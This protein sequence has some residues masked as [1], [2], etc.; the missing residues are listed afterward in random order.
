V[1]MLKIDWHSNKTWGII[2]SIIAFLT[3]LL[4]I[5]LPPYLDKETQSKLWGFLWSNSLGLLALAL[6]VLLLFKALSQDRKLRALRKKIATE[7]PPTFSRFEEIKKVKYGH[8]AYRPLMYYDEGDNPQGVGLNLLKRIFA[9]VDLVD[10][11]RKSLWNNL[12]ENLASK[13]YDVIATPIFETRERSRLISF[14]SPIFYSDIGMYVKKDS[15]FLGHLPSNS[16]SFK[17]AIDLAQRMKPKLVAIE[18]EVSGKMARKYLIPKGAEVTEW[19]TSE[20][21]SVNSLIAALNGGGTESEC[22]VVFAEIFQAEHT[23]SV[24]DG[25]VIN[26]LMSKQL[27]YPVSFAVRKSDYVLR[28]YINL[29]LLEIEQTVK[30]GI[31]G[32]ILEE[33][34][35]HSDYSQYS[36]DYIKRYFLRELDRIDTSSTGGIDPAGAGAAVDGSTADIQQ[37]SRVTSFLEHKR[38]G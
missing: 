5:F 3:L 12:I 33:L 36:L 32:I 27:T 6:I 14:C 13:K 31:L 34:R 2:G 28:N 4:G 10:I 22:E 35:K 7:E 37:Q 19:L 16:K 25:E 30:D 24:R 15:K 18:G 21:A 11:N 8:L 9:N 38:K 1:P 23:P 20:T 26:I 29:K 17:E